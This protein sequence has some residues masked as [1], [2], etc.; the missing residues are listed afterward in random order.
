MKAGLLID[1][2][3]LGN[4]LLIQFVHHNFD[5]LHQVC[6]G[7]GGFDAEHESLL[8]VCI[9]L[10]TGAAYS[11]TILDD[12]FKVEPLQAPAEG[13][14]T[15]VESGKIVGINL[16]VRSSLCL[17]VICGFPPSVVNETL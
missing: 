15:L 5:V 2:D 9:Q 17:I 4:C 1:Y 11:A 7:E 12:S 3:L 14:E 8:D 13:C 16:S 6:D 10:L